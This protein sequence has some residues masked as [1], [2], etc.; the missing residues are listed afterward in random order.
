MFARKVIRDPPQ[1]D[2]PFVPR[3]SALRL[4][5]KELAIV[6]SQSMP[7]VTTPRLCAP[8]AVAGLE[9]NDEEMYQRAEIIRQKIAALKALKDQQARELQEAQLVY[10][11]AEARK[12]TA[13]RK[14]DTTSNKLLELCDGLATS[15]TAEEA[16]HKRRRTD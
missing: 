13:A 11:E 5:S 7:T 16:R 12:E 14:L 15:N 3:G 9:E 4:P 1:L 6:P 2:L 10:D 8:P